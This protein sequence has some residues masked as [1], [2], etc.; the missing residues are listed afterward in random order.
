MH[1]KGPNRSFDVL[2][3]QGRPRSSNVAF[4][5]PATAS[6]TL[7]EIRMPPAGASAF[8][9]RGNVDAVAVEIVAIDDQVAQVQAHAEHK[10]SVCRL[11]AV[12]LGH[13]LLKL[14]GGAQRIDCAGELDQSPVAGQLDQTPSVFRQN[15]IEVFG[16]V[17][18]QAR[19]R[20]ALVTPHQAGVADNVC[21]NDCRQFALLSR[22]RHSP[23]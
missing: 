16:T 6:W 17:L 15:R 18:T 10:R 4:T 21:S 1:P 5:R 19:Q 2:Q 3:R 13:G 14:D 23:G 9:P 8:Q 20:P 11:V 22:Q 12:G 7:R